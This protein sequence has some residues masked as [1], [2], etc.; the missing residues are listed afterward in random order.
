MP[1]G[2]RGEFGF[3]S[4]PFSCRRR[5]YVRT[6]TYILSRCDVFAVIL[7]TLYFNCTC[8]Y[9]TG[10]ESI[11]LRTAQSTYFFLCPKLRAVF[12]LLLYSNYTSINNTNLPM[13][14]EYTKIQFLT[15]LIFSMRHINTHTHTNIR[16]HIPIGCLKNGPVNLY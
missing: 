2:E 9:V 12:K 3:T 13:S 8:R 4:N 11:R 14:L 15:N 10:S 6:S 16:T 5:E 7:S 1:G